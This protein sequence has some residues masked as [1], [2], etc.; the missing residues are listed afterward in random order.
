MPA[1]TSPST[2]GTPPATVPHE[3][4]AVRVLSNVTYGTDP[5]TVLD[6]YWPPSPASSPTPAVIFIHGGGWLVGD[7]G[8]WATNAQKL[9]AA[10]GWPAFSINY[11]MDPNETAYSV[12]PRDVTAAINW[13]KANAAKLDIDPSRIALVGDSAGGHLAMFVA[14]MGSGPSSDPGRVKAVVSWSGIADFPLVATDAGCYSSACPGANATPT[15]YLG[16]LSGRYNGSTLASDQ[17]ALWAA[18]SPVDHVDPTDPEMLLFNSTDEMV[19][20]DQMQEMQTEL[21]SNGV[22][23]QAVAVDGSLH[24]LFYNAI[25]WPKTLSWL[26]HNL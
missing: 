17:P 26:E 10:T 8:A 22:P 15:Q 9:V 16:W 13:V 2:V 12:E 7:K 24:G 14:T 6:E 25:A 11:D 20:I 23:V 5:G 3:P 18:N 21:G 1:R 4:D 19:P